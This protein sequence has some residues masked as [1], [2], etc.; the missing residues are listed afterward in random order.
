[1]NVALILA[2]GTGERV[3]LGV[4]KQFVE[5][6]GKPVIVH[7]LERFEACPEIDC[8]VVACVVS[9][10]GE[11]RSLVDRFGLSKVRSVIEGGPTYQDTVMLGLEF[12]SGMCA[13]DDIVSIHFSASPFVTEEIISDSI[14]VAAEFGNGISAD[15]VVLCIAEKDALDEDRSSLVGLDRD[16]MVG[17]NSPQ[18]FRLGY[19]LDLYEEGRARGILGCIDPHTTS[20]MA[21]LGRRL[22]FSKGSTANIKITTREDLRLFC[23]RLLAGEGEQDGGS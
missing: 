12:V 19:L 2:G 7:T 9:M 11:L 22:Y 8:V 6:E 21:A 4:P 16:R 5:V 23:G 1:M 3:G 13:D 14:R 17:L 10:I 20:L 15:P 18:S